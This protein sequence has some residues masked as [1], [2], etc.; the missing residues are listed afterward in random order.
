MG[1]PILAVLSVSAGAGHVRAAEAIKAAAEAHFPAFEAVHI[2]VMSTVG[3]IF[4]KLYAETYLSLVENHPSLWGIIYKK[5]DKQKA[6]SSLNRLRRAVERLNTRGFMAKI[7]ELNPDRVICTHFLP[8]ELLSRQRAQGAFTRPVWVQVTDFDIHAMWIQTDVTGYFVA[9]DEVAFRLADRGVPR[10]AITVTGIPIMPVFG[11]PPDREAA[12]RELGLDL[13]KKTVLMMSG[14]YGVGGIDQL[15][16]RLLRLPGDFQ[17]VALAGRNEALL[18]S[19][20]KLQATAPGR[21]FPMGFTRTI[22]RLMAVADVAITK[23]GGLTTSEC[24]AM[25]LPMIIV[26]PIPGQEERNADFLLENGVALKA[27]DGAGLEYRLTQLLRDPERLKAMAA[28]ARALGRP[29][30]ARRVL[31]KVC[32]TPPATIDA[33]QPAASPPGRG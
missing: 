24:L 27:Y 1:R 2:D 30:A 32:Q 4:R 7:A 33:P 12:A 22:E 18:A 17:I 15:V 3:E 16:E 25:G 29:D 23:P 21:L 26:S 13:N 8:A 19:L 10:E 6:D 31:E 11:Q 14:G 9:T 28:R 5:S 20:Q